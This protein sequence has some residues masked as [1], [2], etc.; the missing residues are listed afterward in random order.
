METLAEWGIII[1]LGLG[2]FATRLSFLALFAETEPPRWMRRAL[3][4]V[5]PAVLAAIIAPL[6][7]TQRAGA[8]PAPE[9][10]RVI[11]A[12]LAFAV[13]YRTRSTVLTVVVGMA[14]LWGLQ[15]LMK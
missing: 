5:P 4:Y 1:A 9:M 13:A 15:A 7:F 8:L 11:A 12:L 2:T 10:E 14:A 6:L 3:Q